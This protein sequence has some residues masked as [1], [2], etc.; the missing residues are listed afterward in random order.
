M[1]EIIKF[2][3]PFR[4]REVPKHIADRTPPP[5][6]VDEQDWIAA[7][8]AEDAEPCWADSSYDDPECDCRECIAYRSDLEP[9]APAQSEPPKDPTE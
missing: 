8:E 4:A 1:A 9:I 7:A 5:V 6:V 3:R 2:P